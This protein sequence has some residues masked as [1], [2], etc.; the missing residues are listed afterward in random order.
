MRCRSFTA[1]AALS[2][3]VFLAGTKFFRII[4]TT[5]ADDILPD[6]P[7]HCIIMPAPTA[8]LHKADELADAQAVP[9]PEGTAKFKLA[10]CI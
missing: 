9:L 8:L 3:A 6:V 4:N 10:R 1:R 5:S 7:D 2:A